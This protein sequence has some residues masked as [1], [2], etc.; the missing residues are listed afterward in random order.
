MGTVTFKLNSETERILRELAPP[1]RGGRSEV[2]RAALKS[3]SKAVRS[4]SGPSSREIYAALGIRPEK[5]TRSR[6][7]QI[8]RLL[9]EKLIAKRR[10][11]TL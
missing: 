11:G 3:H 9:K 4:Q 8:E 2:I 10:N 6:A 1:G 5:P 7:R